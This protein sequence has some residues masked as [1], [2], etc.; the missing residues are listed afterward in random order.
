MNVGKNVKIPKKVFQVWVGNVE[1]IPK[2]Y[3]ISLDSIQ[4]YMVANG[5]Q[6]KLLQ[7]P[8]ISAFVAEH[9]ADFFETFKN[10]EYDIQRADAIRP[11]WLKKHGGLYMDMDFELLAPIDSLFLTENEVYLL[12][13]SNTFKI[14]GTFTNAIMASVPGSTFWNLYIAHMRKPPKL[15]A[16]GKHLKVMSTTGPFALSKAVKKTTKPITILPNKLIAPC[17]TCDIKE[18][19]FSNSLM[20]QLPGNS[21]HSL[22]SSIYNF[23]FCKFWVIVFFIIAIVLL[24]VMWR[25][26]RRAGRTGN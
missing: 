6:Y 5:W 13:S 19:D 2:S 15:S 8:E 10:F 11:L 21:W 14:G 26:F 1:N 7:E 17:S 12:P 16:I 3:K 25:L 20:R 22:D 24:V 4:K 18:C 23:L 9:Y